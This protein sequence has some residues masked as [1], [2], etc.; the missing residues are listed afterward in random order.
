MG[1][2]VPQPSIY[3]QERSLCRKKV[4]LFFPSPLLF[5][6]SGDISSVLVTTCLISYFLT[7]GFTLISLTDP[8]PYVI[9]F[10]LCSFSPHDITLQV[11]KMQVDLG[12]YIQPS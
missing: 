8:L 10:C 1:W 6:Q 9:L 11:S 2:H 12:H 3:S 5:E 4:H 7:H